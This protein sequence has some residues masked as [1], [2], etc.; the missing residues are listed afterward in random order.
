MKKAMRLM[1][2][3][4]TYINKHG[5]DPT[6]LIYQEHMSDEV[7]GPEDDEESQ[8]DWKV[9]MARVSGILVPTDE[10]I[11]RLKFLEVVE[12][13]WRSREVCGTIKT[14]DYPIILLRSYQPF[15]TS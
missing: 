1:K 3:V 15:F 12:P 9:R 14:R 5:K 11:G 2:A 8:D 13:G 10:A 7:S 4:P 6:P